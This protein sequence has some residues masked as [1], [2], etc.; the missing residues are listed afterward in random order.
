MSTFFK[1][2]DRQKGQTIVMVA[3]FFSA[4]S[5][6][7]M[8]VL[9]EPAL[10]QLG[11]THNLLSS[12][13]SLYVARAAAEDYVYRLANNMD[14]PEK[15]TITIGSNVGSSTVETVG[16]EKFV[17]GSGHV[18]G[19]VRT[20]KYRIVIGTGVQFSFGLQSGRGG[21]KFKN[22]STQAAIHGNIYANGPIIGFGNYIYGSAVSSSDTTVPTYGYI[23]NVHATES[24]YANKVENVEADKDVYA[25]KILNSEIHGDAY[26]RTSIDVATDVDGSTTQNL[27]L[28]DQPPVSLPITDGMVE[29]W[30]D[31]AA[32]GGTIPCDAGKTYHEIPVTTTIGPV[33]I[34][35]DLHVKGETVYLAG[36]VWV[37][38]D[39]KA[40]TFTKISVHPSLGAGSAQIIA[41]H[42]GNEEFGGIID[43]SLNGTFSGSGS[44]SSYVFMISQN[45][46]AENGGTIEAIRMGN[47][48]SGDI[49]L[50][51]GH[52]LIK[53]ANTISLREVTAYQIQVENSAQVVYDDGLEDVLF[54]GEGGG[55]ELNWLKEVK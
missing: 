37:N 18:E 15:I 23:Y 7:I 50:F 11:Q 14:V 39:V 51:A 55:F 19:L 30:K 28:T 10:K 9:A 49:V 54:P 2:G 25:D 43:L 16:Q 42:E 4:V 32:A 46:S 29:A 44:D 35:C 36:P 20:L 1:K 41:D 31:I 45:R 21:I 34:D 48:L 8:L 22:G 3:L 47:T 27:G 12:E 52:G 53:L 38:G 17:S 5:T 26:Y 33:K 6:L 40:D 24:V 13:Q